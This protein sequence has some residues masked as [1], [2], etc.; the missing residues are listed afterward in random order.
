MAAAQR[1]DA[2]DRMTRTGLS[3]RQGELCQRVLAF[4]SI[5][6]SLE[7]RD[8]EARQAY[9]EIRRLLK[10]KIARLAHC[11]AHEVRNPVTTI[12]GLAKR[13]LSQVDDDSSAAEYIKKVGSS[14]LAVE[15]D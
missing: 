11:V 4:D 2:D 3:H 12:G 5:A 15:F 8:E 9:F 10:E 1:L 7:L 14:S 13:L 6:W